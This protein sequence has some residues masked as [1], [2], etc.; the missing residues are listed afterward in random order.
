M[1]VCL[2]MQLASNWLRDRSVLT[3]VVPLI[4]YKYAGGY[5]SD[6]RILKSPQKLA[7]G[8]DPRSMCACVHTP[9][10]LCVCPCVHA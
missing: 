1:A 2:S 6:P 7:Y 8:R 3:I 4:G 9:V 10:Y 5:G